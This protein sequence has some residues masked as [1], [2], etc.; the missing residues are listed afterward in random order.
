MIKPR[1]QEIIFLPTAF[2]MFRRQMFDIR[3]LMWYTAAHYCSEIGKSCFCFIRHCYCSVTNVASIRV[4]H[5]LSHRQTHSFINGIY[6]IKYM[7]WL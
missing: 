3:H 2:S 7:I 4:V 6:N 5:H 1:K